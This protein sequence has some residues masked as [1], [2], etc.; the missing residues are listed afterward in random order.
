MAQQKGVLHKF[1]ALYFYIFFIIK[2]KKTPGP[3]FYNAA[4]AKL[5]L[6]QKKMP[7]QSAVFRS[8][9]KISRKK[10]DVVPQIGQYD[11]S[12]NT[13]SD[14]IRKQREKI[15]RNPI[16]RPRP[17]ALHSESNKHMSKSMVNERFVLKKADEHE[18]YLGPGCYDMPREFDNVKYDAKGNLIMGTDKRFKENVSHGPGPG[19]Y[20]AEDQSKWNKKTYN[21]LFNN[22][23]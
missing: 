14:N 13:I 23:D 4:Q 9:T 19:Y 3:G 10:P 20:V 2:L 12:L 1:Q 6:E 17:A 22:G 16:I 18:K 7:G 5:E 21:L 8:P 15:L 11:Q